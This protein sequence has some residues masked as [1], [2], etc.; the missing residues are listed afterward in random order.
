MAT[1]SFWGGRLTGSVVRPG[2]ETQRASDGALLSFL[3]PTASGDTKFSIGTAQNVNPG[4]DPDSGLRWGRW[5]G[6]S[7]DAGG[8]ALDLASQSLH[9]IY[10]PESASAPAIQRT[11]TVSFAL[12]GNTNPTDARGN[13]GFLGSATLT[14]DFSNFAVNSALSLSVNN[15]VWNASGSGALDASGVNFNG[16]Y[17]TV[18]R[19]QQ[20]GSGNFAGFIVPGATP[21]ALPAGAG[22]GYSLEQGGNTV[23][24]SAAFGKPK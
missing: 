19:N 17:S 11:G 22:M 12:V 10:G 9:W 8:T 4:F 20:S 16:N 2:T 15:D 7:A 3:G 14:A 24:G 23:S 6:G 1:G 5:S 21:D 18:T 13:V